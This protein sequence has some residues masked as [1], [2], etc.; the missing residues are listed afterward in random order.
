MTGDVV[1]FEVHALMCV[2]L[3]K[4]EKHVSYGK[5]FCTTECI[6]LQTRCR[7]NRY[8][9]NRAQPQLITNNL[10]VKM[11]GA[12]F[13]IIFVRCSAV[14]TYHAYRRQ[15][16]QAYLFYVFT[17]F[18]QHFLRP[19]EYSCRTK[20]E[21]FIKIQKLFIYTLQHISTRCPPSRIHF[22]TFHSS[23]WPIG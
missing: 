19:Q 11:R 10:L 18:Y 21:Q 14:S 3:S 8:R 15:N 23:R 6:T 16:S 13:A 1:V 22:N 17:P 7:T 5:V 9:Y 4:A 20:K 2:V 12:W